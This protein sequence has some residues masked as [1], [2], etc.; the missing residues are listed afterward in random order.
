MPGASRL[1]FSRLLVED[2]LHRHTLD[3]LYVIAGRVLGRQNAESRT[4]AGLKA[5]D[6]AVKS[7]VRIRVDLDIDRLADLH[8]LE[9]RFLE[10]RDDPDLVRLRDRH[11]RRADLDELAFFDRL[12]CY[13]SRPPG[14]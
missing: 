9:L 5:F 3:D 4:C 11:Q 13:V 14:R 1:S 10:I 8:V 7:L 12:S 6:L 2:D